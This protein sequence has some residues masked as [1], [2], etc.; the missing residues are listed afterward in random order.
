[1][2]AAVLAIPCALSF[3]VVVRS[4]RGFLGH[5]DAS[6]R[7]W[8]TEVTTAALPAARNRRR[9]GVDRA[10]VHGRAPARGPS[11][12]AVSPC[13]R[14]EPLVREAGDVPALPDALVSAS[15]VSGAVGTPADRPPE[16]RRSD[17]LRVLFAQ[18]RA[19]DPFGFPVTFALPL[20][21]VD[22]AGR[23]EHWCGSSRSPAMMPRAHP[24]AAD[25]T[26]RPHPARSTLAHPR[27]LPRPPRPPSLPSSAR[28]ASPRHG[29]TSRSGPP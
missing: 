20:P 24:S 21:A 25:L 12:V 28:P 23:A 17:G 18:K 8:C 11:P 14:T 3:G 13:E 29:G 16:T 7:N 22:A 2:P 15:E 26:P 5:R 4:P 9:R 1:M 27:P 6:R 10:A 19:P